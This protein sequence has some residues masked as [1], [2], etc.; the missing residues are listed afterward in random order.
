MDGSKKAGFVEQVRR[1]RARFVQRAGSVLGE[2]LTARVLTTFVTEEVGRW[3]NR[4]CS[5]LMT[6][7]MFI[8]QVLGADHSC[9]CLLQTS[10]KESITST[11]ST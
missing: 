9:P 11:L 3:R 7:V 4:L 6:V 2:V 5:P 1:F 8:E 10:R